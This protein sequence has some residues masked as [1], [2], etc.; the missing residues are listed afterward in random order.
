MGNRLTGELSGA[1]PVRVVKFVV[2]GEPRSKQRPRV[3]TRGT[4]TPKETIERERAVRDAWYGRGEP[5]FEHQVVIEIDF[6]NATRHR[7]DI[8]NM[9]KLVLD[10]LNGV[11]FVDDHD[12]VGLNL[13]KRYT[14]IGRPRTEVVIRE[15]ILW[16]DES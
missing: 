12:V 1:S 4:F 3:T 6:F 14:T 8:D 13:T 7:R 16:P 5:R 10:G 2:P 11:A 9:A 15:V